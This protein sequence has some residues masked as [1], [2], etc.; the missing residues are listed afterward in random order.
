VNML[1]MDEE[2][3]D[4]VDGK[5]GERPWI[6]IL[7]ATPHFELHLPSVFNGKEKC[8]FTGSKEKEQQFEI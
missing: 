8:R 6:K 2:V 5:Y 4:D 7:N 1:E 3:S